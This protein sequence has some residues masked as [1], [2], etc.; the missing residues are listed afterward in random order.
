MTMS[1]GLWTVG[2]HAVLAVLESGQP[3]DALWLQQDR[4]DQRAKK[5]I[6]AA[7]RRGVRFDVVP[8]ARLDG[9]AEGVVHNGCAV[10]SAPVAFADLDDVMVGDDGPGRIV[11]VDDVDDPH[12]LGAVIRTAAALSLDAL[13][14][15]GPSAPP[16]GGAVAKA[17]AGLLG[18]VPVVRVKVAADALA[19]LRENGYWAFGADAAGTVLSEV[20]TTPRW[21]L[22]LGAEGRGLRAKTR[23]QIDEFVAIPMAAGVESL[24]LSVSAGILLWELS[25]P[26]D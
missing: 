20:R 10:R 17:A 3:V 21:V 15:A 6:A 7:R 24:N 9:V 13:V 2:F 18:R 1:E 19:R 23:S 25:R 12:N 14:I 8:R 11:L 22:C 26:S 16:L 4:R 5:I